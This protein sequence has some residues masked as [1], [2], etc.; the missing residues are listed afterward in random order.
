MQDS[1]Y[2]YPNSNVLR[3]KLNI[4][5]QQDLFEAEKDL[6]FI[7]LQELQRRP[8]RGSLDL[9]HLC[10]IHKYIFQDIYEWA[11]EIRTVEI[12]KGNLFCTTSCIYSFAKSVFDKYYY[13]CFANK[14]DEQEF[15]RVLSENYG[16]LNALHP[17]REGN[18]RTQREF[19]RVLCL[20]CGYD[21]DLSSTTHKAMLEASKVSF[22]KGDNLPLRLIFDKAVHKVTKA[23][24]TNANQLK[25][26]TVDDLTIDLSDDTYDYYGYQEHEKSSIYDTLYQEKI[27]R[28]NSEKAYEDIR[29]QL[30]SAK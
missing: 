24:N 23:Y 6:T 20:E 5:N 27:N 26:L 19:A 7:R 1:V 16:D 22:N 29:Q 2:C 25:I 10:A 18:G 9:E 13:Q 11:G 14:D 17:F 8:I 4:T 30:N 3:N 12:G 15:V 21:F 28:M